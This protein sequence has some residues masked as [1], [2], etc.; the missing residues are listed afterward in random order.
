MPRK[1]EVVTVKCSLDG[2][3]IMFQRKPYELRASKFL[4]FCC[5]SHGAEYNRAKIKERT[6]RPK[7]SVESRPC[8]CGCNR[9]IER[10]PC[11][12][13]KAEKQSKSGQF[14]YETACHNKKL[15]VKGRRFYNR[16][17]PKTKSETRPC[18]MCSKPV[19]RRPCEMPSL[20]VPVFCGHEHANQY[21]NRRVSEA[22]EVHKICANPNCSLPD[23]K[24]T[25]MR[26][27]MFRK[28][29]SEACMGKDPSLEAV[30]ARRA[31]GVKAFMVNVKKNAGKTSDTPIELALQAALTAAGIAWEPQ[32]PLLDMTVV[33]IFVAPDICVYADG[34][35]WHNLPE[36]KV[37]DARNNAALK[38]AGYRVIRF[39]GSEIKKD[40][41]ACAAEIVSLLPKKS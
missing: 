4:S 28:Y 33:D 13:R 2:C 20:D 8:S 41:A 14:F 26:C 30:A 11:E 5:R 23:R 12:W 7:G 6:G 19:T 32:V 31:S 9:M 37:R 17:G 22:A 21:I 40:A 16:P 25:V 3:S 38:A 39:S 1:G 29:C 35:L 27:Q 18:S 15:N 36:A 10:T 24:F 34:L